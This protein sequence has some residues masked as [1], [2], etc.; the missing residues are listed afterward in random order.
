MPDYPT[1][2]NNT[3]RTVVVG[4]TGTGKTVCGLW[5]L[6]NYNLD[7]PWVIFNLKGDE[8]IE[9]IE[10]AS[11]VDI[12]YVPSK[13]D[14]GLFVV[15]PDPWDLEGS[16]KE[17]S[18]VD[19]LLI[20]L[21][22]RG[23]VGIFVDEMV[24][25]GNSKAITLCCT[26]GRAKHIPMIMCSQRPVGINRYAFSEATYVQVFDLNIQD[27]IDTV[28]S[29]VPLDWDD[30]KELGP[31]QSWYYEVETNN[32]FRF[33]PVPNMEAIHAVFNQKLHRKL[34]RI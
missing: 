18:R 20:K 3:N 11:F 2:P 1:L 25:L 32:I 6:S 15:T 27:D 31:H 22:Q 30:E 4:R 12:G 10:K 33:N 13:K 28:E 24:P 34:V 26:Q 9:A 21:W 19:Q 16:A 8:H 14:R 5:H 7:K 23:D 29:Y 17:K